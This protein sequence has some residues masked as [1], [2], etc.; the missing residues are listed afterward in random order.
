MAGLCEGGNEPPGSLKASRD[1]HV[2]SIAPSPHTSTEA[3]QEETTATTTSKI[4]F[5]NPT[6]VSG[7]H[8]IAGP[9]RR[10]NSAL[11]CNTDTYRHLLRSAV[12]T[13]DEGDNAGKMSPGS[14]TESYPAFAHLGLR[15]NHGRNFNQVTC[16]DRES[17]PGHLVSRPDALTVTP[18]GFVKDIVY[19]QK[20]RNIDDVRVKIT[21]A[22]QQIDPLMLTGM[23]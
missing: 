14:S 11:Q 8:K 6:L 22:F 20:P 3:V 2:S 4:E 19:S 17:N 5:S 13:P 18:Q 10:A 23:G 21:Q 7:L 12:R 16:P 1:I 9:P 15:E